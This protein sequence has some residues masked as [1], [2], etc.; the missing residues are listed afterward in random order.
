MKSFL[1]LFALLPLYAAVDGTVINQ[2]TGKPA[3][4][5]T[6]TLYK[7]GQAGPEAL[8]SVHTDAQGKFTI[9]QDVQGGPHNLQATYEGVTYVHILRP[10]MPASGVTLEVY[11]AS[12]QPGEAKVAQHFFILQPS[13]GQMVVSEVFLYRNGGKVAYNDPAN[14]TLKFYLPPA[15]K[16]EVKV[17]AKGPNGMPLQQLAQKTGKPDVY[18]VDFPV[19][20]GETQFEVNYMVPYT[21]PGRFGSKDLVGSADMMLVAPTG[22]D[23]K[24]DGVEFARE[25]PRTQAKIYTA[26]KAGFEVEISGQMQASEQQS[27]SGG[28]SGPALE[29]VMPKL[30]GQIDGSAGFWQKIFAVKWILLLALAILALGMILLYRQEPPAQAAATAPAT[31]PDRDRKAVPEPSKEKHERRRR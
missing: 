31:P 28:G 10:G 14:G 13:R 4:D 11:D 12:K 26:K 22:V 17:Q 1:V 25:E 7:L 20:P 21:S 3:K 9:Q 15:A 2:T 29:Q 30:F 5:A 16:G 27:D 24:G 18:K 23:L 19:R 8:Q 6:V